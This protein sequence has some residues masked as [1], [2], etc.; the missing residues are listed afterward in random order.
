MFKQ[1]KKINEGL[2]YLEYDPDKRITVSSA[3]GLL[4]ILSSQYIILILNI[5]NLNQNI[6]TQFLHHFLC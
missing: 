2:K 6:H 5:H 3:K 4:E 1:H